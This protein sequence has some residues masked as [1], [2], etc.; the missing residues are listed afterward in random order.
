MHGNVYGAPVSS[1]YDRLF[2]AKL[3]S[4]RVFHGS[5]CIVQL[6]SKLEVKLTGG[7]HPQFLL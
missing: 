5:A 6:V 2:C 1:T 3:L 7:S 4:N